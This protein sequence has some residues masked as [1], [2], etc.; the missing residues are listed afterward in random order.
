MEIIH[1]EKEYEKEYKLFEKLKQEN[2][3]YTQIID[4]SKKEMEKNNSDGNRRLNRHLKKG[5]ELYYPQDIFDNK[6]TEIKKR[7]ND[8][9]NEIC[10]K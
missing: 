1:L 2:D 5:K 10:Q 6:T 4:I 8:I 9:N 7:I 3:N